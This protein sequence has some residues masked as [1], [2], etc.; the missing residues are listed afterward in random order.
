M[1]QQIVI[2]FKLKIFKYIIYIFFWINLNF[3]NLLPKPVEHWNP[4]QLL[5]ITQVEASD[6]NLLDNLFIIINQR[7]LKIRWRTAWIYL[8]FCISLFVSPLGTPVLPEVY[9]AIAKSPQWC[10]RRSLFFSPISDSLPAFDQRSF[11]G[12]LK[13]ST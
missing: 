3:I 1:R 10:F 5:Y 7:K 8:Y 12:S 9:R 4:H 13:A 6:D 11:T 2:P